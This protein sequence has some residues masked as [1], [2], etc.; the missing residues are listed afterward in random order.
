MGASLNGGGGPHFDS[1]TTPS[2]RDSVFAAIG[3]NGQFSNRWNV[4]IYYNVDFGSPTSVTSIIS[5][6]IGFAF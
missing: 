4:A 2:S 1:I 3:V 6:D 5:A